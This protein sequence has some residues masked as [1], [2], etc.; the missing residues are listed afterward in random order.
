MSKRSKARRSKSIA[1][2]VQYLSEALV[3]NGKAAYDGP[4]KKRWHVKDMRNIRPMTDNQKEMFQCFF[5]GDDHICVHGSAGTGKTFLALYLAF[6]DVLDADS[7]YDRVLVV[8]SAVPSRDMGFMPGSLDEK[9]ALYELPYMDILG[10]LFRR[11]STYGE[12]KKNGMIDFISTSYIRGL[13]WDN[14]IIIV[15]EG[16]NMT[17]HEINSIMTRVGESSRVIFTGD[18]P[19]TDLRKRHE[20]S[21]MEQFLDIIRSMENF[22]VINFST[23]DIVRS[24]FVKEW[25]I[26]SEAYAY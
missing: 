19:Q 18:L 23:N 17:F 25:I 21:G 7:D 3:A 24:S 11:H 8:R 22:S 14:A 10:D 1:N 6:Q 9:L 13:T 16:Q 5:Q 4:E 26:A 12:M 2:N 20:H 15:D